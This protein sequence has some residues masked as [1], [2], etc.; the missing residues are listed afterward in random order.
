MG[1]EKISQKIVDD[2]EKEAKAI[3]NI[4]KKEAKKSIEKAYDFIKIHKEK[5]LK[6]VKKTLE[7]KILRYIASVNLEIKKENLKSKR[8]F[9]DNLIDKTVEHITEDK[10]YEDFLKKRIDD[11]I[12]EDATIY[13]NASD[14]KIY[15]SLFEETIKKNGYKSDIS[16]DFVDIKGGFIIKKGKI[17]I[18]CT[19][20]SI[21]ESKH[22]EI[23]MKINRM[24]VK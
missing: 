19:L 23:L 9:I 20:D 15:K 11:A 13:M 10:L 4:A 24:L 1:I 22:D 18:D 8:D 14:Y 16:R 5:D 21:I 6:K 3:I 2:A 7:I 17:T 12:I